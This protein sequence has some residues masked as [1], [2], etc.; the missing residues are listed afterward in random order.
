MKA[1]VLG[2]ELVNMA[3]D[4][5]GLADAQ[6]WPDSVVASLV[7]INNLLFLSGDG[8]ARGAPATSSAAA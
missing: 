4:L 6:R 8:V 3:P 7:V 2:L 5:L 1:G